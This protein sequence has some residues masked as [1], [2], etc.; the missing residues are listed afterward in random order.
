MTQHELTHVTCKLFKEK[1][2]D[3]DTMISHKKL[4]FICKICDKDLLFMSKLERHMK[5]HQ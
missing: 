3:E 5:I 2:D 4:N 1:F